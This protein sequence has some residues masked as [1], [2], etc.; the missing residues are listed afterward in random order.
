MTSVVIHF[1]AL[2]PVCAQRH[3][4]SSSGKS[5]VVCRCG[6]KITVTATTRKRRAKKK[7]EGE[8]E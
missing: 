4:G 1:E 2:C 7:A 8:P 6:S 5:I 3:F